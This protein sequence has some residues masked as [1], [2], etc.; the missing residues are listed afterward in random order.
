MT[1]GGKAPDNNSASNVNASGVTSPGLD[2]VLSYSL[3]V[4]KETNGSLVGA[5]EQRAGPEGESLKGLGV[6]LNISSAQSAY[7]YVLGERPGAG[8][9]P[10]HYQVIYPFLVNKP[11]GKVLMIKIPDENTWIRPLAKEGT[12]RLW[13][14]WA[15]NP[16]E[17]IEYV[18]SLPKEA[19]AQLD[20]PEQDEQNRKIQGVL[21]KHVTAKTHTE[22]DDVK[23]QT[24]VKWKGSI[25]AYELTLKY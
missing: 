14:V 17:E 15:D 19:G 7:L 4:Q 20:K 16:V 12:R 10:P 5:P 9:G 8:N 13:L 22:R 6:W 2:R 25:L 18:K 11:Q 24:D 23:K 1:G 3:T 21:V